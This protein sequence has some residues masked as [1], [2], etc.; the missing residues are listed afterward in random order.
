MRGKG[1]QR[2]DSG[3]NN[4]WPGSSSS[5]EAGNSLAGGVEEERR[6]EVG[7]EGRRYSARRENSTARDRQRQGTLLVPT[8]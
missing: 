5:E 7:G 2:E 8:K 1:I 6:L 3:D 4:N